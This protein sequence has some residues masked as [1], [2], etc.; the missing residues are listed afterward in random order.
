M[1]RVMLIGQR[2]LRK[3]GFCMKICW[4]NLEKL[5]Y[6]KKTGK[7]Y[8][9]TNTFIYKEK[10]VVCKKPFLAQI[11]NNGNY[12]SH[13][14][15]CRHEH[16]VGILNNKG[17][18]NPAWKDGLKAI[19]PNAYNRRGKRKN[20][21]KVSMSNKKYKKAKAA[22]LNAK[23]AKRRAEKIMQTPIDANFKEI[24]WFYEISKQ[25]SKRIGILGYYHVDH[26]IPLSRGGLHHEDNLQILTAYQNQSKRDKITKQREETP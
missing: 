18:N 13:S 16:I 24:Y 15:S 25:M 19:D 17:E 6:S 1:P 4:D 22:K 20:S 10:C 9:K 7:W 21:G 11:Y 2:R 23:R 12:C 5:R 3:H 14:C 8:K 26:I